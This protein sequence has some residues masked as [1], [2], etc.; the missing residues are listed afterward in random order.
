MHARRNA[1]ERGFCSGL[2][3]KSSLKK[4]EFF[5]IV[6][7]SFRA[8]SHALASV[9]CKFL[10]TP[11]VRFFLQIDGMHISPDVNVVVLERVLPIAITMSS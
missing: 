2:N 7:T 4:K 9:S 6:K 5:A 8:D 10:S 1:N 11:Y 3:H